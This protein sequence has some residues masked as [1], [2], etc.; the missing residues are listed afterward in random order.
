[1]CL[2]SEIIS[3][4]SLAAILNEP[5]GIRFA[6]QAENVMISHHVQLNIKRVSIWD[7]RGLFLVPTAEVYPEPYPEQNEDETGVVPIRFLIVRSS[8]NMEMSQGGD[9]FSMLNLELHW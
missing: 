9:D 8:F 4:T 7:L 5:L 3:I 6:K 1:M 2:V